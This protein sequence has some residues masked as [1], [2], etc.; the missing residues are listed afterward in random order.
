MPLRIAVLAAALGLLA[1]AASFVAPNA[2]HSLRLHASHSLRMTATASAPSAEQTA[3]NVGVANVLSEAL[4]YIMQHAGETI[5]IKYGGHAMENPEASL[6]FARDV[7]LLKQCG[8]NPVVV[9]GGGPQIAAMLKRLNISTSFVEGLRVTDAETVEVAEMVLCGSINK[10]IAGSIK[11]A[12]GRAVG[13]SG[14]DDSLILAE[15]YKKIITDPATGQ[16][17]M[18]DIGFVGEIKKVN[19]QVV[20]DLIQAGIIP[21]IAPIGVDERGQTYNCNADTAAGAIASALKANRLLLLTDVKGVLDKEGR[22]LQELTLE[23]VNNLMQ[24]GTIYGGMIPKL[25]TALRAV[26]EGVG[27]SIVLDGRVKH[28]LLLELFTSGGAGTLIKLD[29]R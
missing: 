21:V 12:G 15:K 18:L 7:V 10:G 8:V 2:A 4:P 26:Q 11:Q 23:D 19:T 1:P 20:T 22:L 17:K 27:A 25:D 5:V 16:S 6:N 3:K 13:L 29:D 14:K 24:D 9:H 28:A